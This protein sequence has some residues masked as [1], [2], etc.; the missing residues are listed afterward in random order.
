H[1]GTRRNALRISCHLFHALAFDDHN[2][3]APHVSLA[4]PQFSELYGFPIS[5]CATRHLFRCF[6]LSANRCRHKHRSHNRYKTHTGLL[7]RRLWNR[8]E[9]IN[10]RLTLTRTRSRFR[11]SLKPAVDD[12]QVVLAGGAQ[13]GGHNP[14]DA[15]IAGPIPAVRGP[16]WSG[17]RDVG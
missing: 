8:A 4:V 10:A 7:T 15:Y 13:A 16:G 2:R 11:P 9:L 12:S 17:R 1:L 14:T 5:A 6:F 3:V